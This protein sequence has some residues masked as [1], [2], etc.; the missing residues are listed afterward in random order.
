MGMSY[1]QRRSTAWF[2]VVS[3]SVFVACSGDDGS[4]PG[5]DAGSG[6]GAADGSASDAMAAG[7][8]GTK[9]DD[10]T[11][12]PD[13]LLLDA[14]QAGDVVEDGLALA[15]AAPGDVDAPEGGGA[16]YDAS[17]ANAATGDVDAPEGGGASYDTS[18]ADA[19]AGES[20]TDAT[21]AADDGSDAS[22]GANAP[23]GDAASQDGDSGDAVA[24]VTYSFPFASGLDGWWLQ[25]VTPGVNGDGG[26]W[27]LFTNSGVSWST[28]FG[29]PAGS[30]KVDAA[31]DDG[32]QKLTVALNFGFP[33]V[34]FTGKKISVSL[35]LASGNPGYFFVFS[36]D[37]SWDWK[38]NGPMLFPSVAGGAWFTATLDMSSSQGFTSTA[39]DSTHIR[40]LGIEFDSGAG[41]G[42]GSI[43]PATIY[44]DNITVQ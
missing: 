24:G 28:T 25:Q 5:V 14:G 27:P 39:F 19:E 41:S 3:V 12:A 1:L 29:D 43:L 10:A 11:E 9:D 13:A 26:P 16:S 34:D 20:D 31:F 40:L 22:G 33:Y 21:P 42:P 32:G 7:D 2:G 38:D 17:L 18:L 15:D 8:A 30:M 36:Q 4:L 35:F 6:R 37:Q 44:V 23:N